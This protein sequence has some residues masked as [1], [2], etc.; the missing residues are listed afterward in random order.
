MIG[1]TLIPEKITQTAG[2]RQD[3]TK[4]SQEQRQGMTRQDTRQ[5]KTRQD[6]AT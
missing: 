3:K 1:F 2:E 5:D 4:Q 6:N